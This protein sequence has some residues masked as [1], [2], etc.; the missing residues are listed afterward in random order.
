MKLTFAFPDGET[1]EVLAYEG[2]NLLQVAQDNGIEEIEGACEG[3]C[4]CSTCHIILSETLFNELPALEEEEEDML[5][6]AAGLTDTSRLGCQVK[7]TKGMDG[8]TIKL[9][10]EAFNA[11]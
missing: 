1:Q 5:D 2:E 4:C 3:T 7:V 8:A 9:P 6:L 11:L 10:E